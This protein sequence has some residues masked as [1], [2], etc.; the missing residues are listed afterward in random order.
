[1][2]YAILL[3]G[4]VFVCM[5]C[6]TAYSAVTVMNSREANRN[7]QADES[8]K[9]ADLAVKHEANMAQLDQ[10]NRLAHKRINTGKRR[11][12]ALVF[13]AGDESARS[14]MSGAFQFKRVPTEFKLQVRTRCA[15]EGKRGGGGERDLGGHRCMSHCVRILIPS[16][17]LG[18]RVFVFSN[19]EIPLLPGGIRVRP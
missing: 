19:S 1:M 16:V 9:R 10:L 3:F 18:D 7:C 14:A 13:S 6:A 5:A 2:K 17:Q 12:E 8:M 11:K 4:F 15:E